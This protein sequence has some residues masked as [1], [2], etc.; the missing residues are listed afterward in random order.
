MLAVVSLMLLLLMA[1]SANA[2]IDPGSG[3]Y[4]FQLLI[5]GFL[6]ALFA[7]KGLWRNAKGYIIEHLRKKNTGQEDC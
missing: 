4:V 1:D 7:A 3:S 5:A 6:G 2:Y